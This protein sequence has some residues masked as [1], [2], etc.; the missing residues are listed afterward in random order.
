MLRRVKRCNSRHGVCN[1]VMKTFFFAPFYTEQKSMPAFHRQSLLSEMHCRFVSACT[2]LSQVQSYKQQFSRHLRD[3]Y[4]L[5]IVCAINL[6]TVR[7]LSVQFAM[8][9]NRYDVLNLLVCQLTL[10]NSG[11]KMFEKC[12]GKEIKDDLILFARSEM[13]NGTFTCWSRRTFTDIRSQF[14]IRPSLPTSVSFR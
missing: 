9:T 3:C 2:N 5:A 8:K 6:S 12:C 11:K 13:R 4:S 1:F 10:K 14:S 7:L